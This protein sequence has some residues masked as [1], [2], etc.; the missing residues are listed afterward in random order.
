MAP[1][2]K[3]CA[4][5]WSKLRGR[6]REKRGGDRRREHPDLNAVPAGGD[7]DLLALHD[8][9]L[10]LHDA[11]EHFAAV[12]AVKAKLVELRFF[13]GLSLPQAA[14]CLDMSLST[15]NRS[16]K[17]ARAWLYEAM[18]RQLQNESMEEKTTD[19]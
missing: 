15:A 1:L 19:I 8:D 12:D 16:W 10:T 3:P 13:A 2:H 5:S 4:A 9:L 11:L 18:A 14:E 17:Y 7:D 6:K